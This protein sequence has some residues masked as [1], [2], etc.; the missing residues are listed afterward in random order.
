MGRN[1][2]T[3]CLLVA[4]VAGCAQTGDPQEIE[5]AAAM[6]RAAAFMQ[7]VSTNGGY[8]GI[9]SLS[10][11]A[12]RYGEA[13]YES[14]GPTEIWVQPPGTPSVGEAYLRAYLTTGDEQYLAAAR[15]VGRALAWGQRLEGGWDHLV[16]VA[17]LTPNAVA[18]DRVSGDCTFDDDISQGALRFLM[19]LDAVLDEAWLDNA[20]A[21][22]IGFFMESQYPNGAWPLWYPLRGGYH[23]YYTFNDNTTNDCITIMM[24]IHER[25]GNQEYLDRVIL[26][27]DFIIAS[28]IA[29]QPGWAQQYNFLMEPDWGRA[30][31]PPAVCSAATS[32]NIRTLV[33]ISLH[34]GD[35][36]YL[37][38]I[39]AAIAWLDTSELMDNVWARFYEIGTNVPI[40]GDRDGLIHYTFEEISQERRQGY[41]WHGAYGVRSIIGYYEAVVGA[42]IDACNASLDAQPTQQEL[43][44]QLQM[45]AGGAERAMAAL[46]S[47]GRWVNAD[48]WLYIEDFVRNFNELVDCLETYSAL[49]SE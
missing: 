13:F 18:P 30:F 37:V 1:P 40:Y 21:L 44:S 39:P 49:R 8:V 36:R 31:E 16:D 12:H 20:V 22:G 45:R 26:G 34:T 25:Y 46:D 17:A 42:G 35:E 47:E 32:R 23:D 15:D 29:G 33:D 19:N 43:E 10:D 38:P 27:G 14:A 3:L 6:E 41:S 11:P 7:S 48:G 5:V 9:L 2:I 24:K 4:V 28:Q